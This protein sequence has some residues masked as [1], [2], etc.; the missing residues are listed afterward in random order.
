MTRRLMRTVLLAA[1]LLALPG[2]LLPAYAQDTV[3]V[4]NRTIYPGEVVTSDSLEEVPLR[5]QVRNLDAIAIA[6]PQI[7]GK[8]AKRT[9]LPGRMIAVSALRDAWVVERGAPV[10]VRFVHGGL[11]ITV[12]GVPLQPGAAGDTI[13]VRNSDT[14]AVFVGIVMPDGSIRVTAS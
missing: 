3:V 13:Q 8:V 7:D 1:T 12:A 4:P 14:G 11:E 9:L 5:R 6:V 2:A 10:Q